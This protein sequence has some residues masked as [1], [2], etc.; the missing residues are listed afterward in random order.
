[1]DDFAKETIP[2]R[3]GTPE[4]NRQNHSKQSDGWKL[5]RISRV[6]LAVM[7][8]AVCE[9]E[10]FGGYPVSVSINELWSWPRN[11][12]PKRMPLISTASWELLR[13]GALPGNVVAMA[14]F[15]G[16]D[17]SN[18]T[19]SAAAYDSAQKTA[20]GQKKPL[21]VIDGALGLRQ[22]DAV[23]GH[24][25]ALGE[26]M[27]RLAIDNN[28]IPTAI[29]VSV[30]PR[31]VQARICPAF[32]VGEMAGRTAAAAMGIPLN[33]FSHQEGHIAA[34]LFAT[35]RLPLIDKCFI[36][37]HISGGTTECMAVNGKMNGFTVSV[38]SATTDLHAGQ[39]WT[40]WALCWDWG[41]PPD[42]NWTLSPPVFRRSSRKTLVCG[43]NPSL[44]GLENDAGK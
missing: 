33:R 4:R 20:A 42:R 19:T 16:I 14:V 6:A 11:L 17:T 18:Y 1:V 24:V 2:L 44:S 7:R 43:N 41:F 8:V 31:S 9:I 39:P 28:S 25:K 34:A 30:R 15:L 10:Y 29:G 23:F 37:L 5:D 38:L 32:L 21:P 26:V 36:A 3:G 22:S 27:E 35:N 40:G 12:P 13:A